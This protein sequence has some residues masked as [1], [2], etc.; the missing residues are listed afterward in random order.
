MSGG[1]LFRLNC[2]V[3]LGSVIAS[4]L[5]TTRM[6]C[7]G[8]LNAWYDIV[9]PYRPEMMPTYGDWLHVFPIVS[10][11][12]RQGAVAGSGAPIVATTNRRS[13][14]L[15]DWLGAC[16]LNIVRVRSHRESLKSLPKL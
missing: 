3:T 11:A 12:N 16:L 9:L 15:A 5:A 4:A 1:L 8:V 10:A 2:L 13:R 7:P 6:A 14:I